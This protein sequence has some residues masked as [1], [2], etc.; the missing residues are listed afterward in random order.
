M[1]DSEREQ[2]ERERDRV[3]RE[4]HRLREADE[5]ANPEDRDL[6]DSVD[7][8]QRRERDVQDD[9]PPY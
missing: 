5:A 9:E 8:E 3:A 4:L 7:E 1:A 6:V 2:R